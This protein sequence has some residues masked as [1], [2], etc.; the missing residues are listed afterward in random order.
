[1]KLL[2]KTII[3]SGYTSTEHF[4]NS[5]FHPDSVGGVAIA[6]GFTTGIAF[7]VETFLGVQMPAILVVLGFFLLELF[8]GIKASFNEGYG[9]S[10]AKFGKGFLKLAVYA[11]FV[12]FTNML[13]LYGPVETYFGYEFN[14]YRWLHFVFAN[15]VILN[16]I[17]SNLENFVRL[18]W[19][20]RYGVIVKVAE[21]FNLHVLKTKKEKDERKISE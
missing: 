14:H 9:W 12:G 20:D 10:T 21:V 11:V 18:G 17:L 13:A 7:Y 4:T 5:T 2:E 6:T 1:M 15:F 16:Y 8:T 19:E 3:A